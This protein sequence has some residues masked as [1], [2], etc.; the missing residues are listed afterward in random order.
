MRNFFHRGNNATPQGGGMLASALHRV[1]SSLRPLYR[2]AFKPLM[3]REPGGE[4]IAIIGATAVIVVM[5]LLGHEFFAAYEFRQIDDNARGGAA[6]LRYENGARPTM[7]VP[8]S[9]A[10]DE[11]AK[12]TESAHS[13]NDTTRAHGDASEH[14]A[15]RAS[16]KLVGVVLS[17]DGGGSA[18]VKRGARQTMLTLGDTR[19]GMTLIALSPRGAT[20][21]YDGET[22]ELINEE[23]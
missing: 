7:K 19:D 3:T 5:L 10:H 12:A 23:K 16:V 2:R 22:H 14:I 8:F 21:E 9:L 4:R 15:R 17:A 20:L 18:I 13:T 1:K 6:G 11:P